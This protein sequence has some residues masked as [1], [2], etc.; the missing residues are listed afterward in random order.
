MKVFIIF[1]VLLTL[2]AIFFQYSR[3]KNLKK[4]FVTLATFAAIITLAVVGNI[5]RQVMPLFIAHIILLII[6]WGALIVYMIKERY[7]WWLIFSPLVTIILFLLLEI[8]VGSGHEGI[9]PHS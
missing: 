2:I 5:T 9:L 4:L 1:V 6:S 8:M 7:Y 3:N